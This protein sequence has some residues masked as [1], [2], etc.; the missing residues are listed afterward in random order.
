MPK[1]N[2]K[3]GFKRETNEASAFTLTDDNGNQYIYSNISKTETVPGISDGCGGVSPSHPVFKYWFQYYSLPS[4]SYSYYLSKIVTRNND[5]VNYKYDVAYGNYS[6]QWTERRAALPSPDGACYAAPPC[7]GLSA[8]QMNYCRVT[9]ISSTR[10][11]LIRFAYDA[12]GRKDLSGDN[13]L[14][15]VEV[16]YGNQLLKRY[17]L[18]Y[19]YFSTGNTINPSA[20]DYRLKLTGIQE[21]GL[22]PYKFRYNESTRMPHRLSFGQDHWGYYNG[23]DDNSTLLPKNPESGFTEGANRDVGPVF[24]Q[25]GVLNGIIYPTGG[26]TTFMYEQNDCKVEGKVRVVQPGVTRRILSLP[27]ETV[28]GTFI[29]PSGAYRILA[30]WNAPAVSGD[31]YV[32]LTNPTGD[33]RNYTGKSK[34]EGEAQLNVPPGTY[35]VEIK[36]NS[37]NTDPYYLTFSWYTASEVD[38]IYNQQVGGLRIK[39]IT[40]Y[41]DTITGRVIASK[42]YSYNS[43]DRPQFSSGMPVNPPKYEYQTKYL[44]YRDESSLTPWALCDNITQTAGSVLPLG[45][46]QGG[47]T[48]YNNVQVMDDAIGKNGY[49]RYYFSNSP[50]A[51]GF[52]QYPFTPFIY[53]DWK[54]GQLKTSATAKFNDNNF[55]IQA[56]ENKEYFNEDIDEQ[57]SVMGSSIG[58]TS[59]IRVGPGGHI[60]TNSPTD[61]TYE[62]NFSILPY[63]F[64]TGKSWLLKEEKVMFPD[65]SINDSLVT[66]TRY[67]YNNSRHY[68]PVRIE[69]ST[70]AGVNITKYK[71]PLDYDTASITDASGK[72]ITTL[73]RKNISNDPVEIYR[74]VKKNGSQDSLVTQGVFRYFNSQFPYVDSVQYLDINVPTLQFA[75]SDIINGQLVKSNLY[76]TEVN[77]IRYDEKYNVLEQNFKNGKQ[78]EAFIWNYNKALPVAKVDNAGYDD[79]AYTS[80]EAENAGNWSF[81]GA[82]LADESSPTGSKCYNIQ[83]GVISRSCNTAKTYVVSYWTKNA[84]PFG[85]AGTQNGYPVKGRSYN[86]WTCYEHKISGVSEVRISGTGLIDE[87][88]FYPADASMQTFTYNPLIG[89]SAGCDE[90]NQISY[91]IYDLQGRLVLVKD[92]DGKVLKKLDYQYQIGVGQ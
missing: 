77:G 51:K 55:I 35:T 53:R 29:I 11:H 34:T 8:V 66:T 72:G 52:D 24:S 49:T 84:T 9:E 47:A 65:N 78:K 6:N 73:A 42:S 69:A 87:L 80:F 54:N 91:Y 60:P 92:Q 67:F 74:L 14:K 27:G 15:G 86:G 43:F 70:S 22:P 31:E 1:K 85:I 58:I 88:R 16:Y 4:Y 48:A 75:G 33:T 90:K 18:S 44:T 17:M 36:T 13:A 25:V 2:I 21:E 79:I 40:S 10:G 71:Y 57:S 28:T 62:I 81:A 30:R 12:A 46:F 45:V 39:N 23:R 59:I 89:L 7:K 56:K 32:R 61:G 63:Y 5:T 20:D 50:F 76:K 38:T 82:P 41:Q 83:G 3:V 68:N 26:K 64:N 37:D 19:D